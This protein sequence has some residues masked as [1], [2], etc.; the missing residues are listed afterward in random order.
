MPRFT[1]FMSTLGQAYTE[2]FELV[3]SIGAEAAH[4]ASERAE[5]YRRKGD[6][7]LARYWEKV[8][9]FVTHLCRPE[10]HSIH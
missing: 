8:T 9:A 6:E 10:G 2:A 1:V 4:V 5:A 7:A 3:E